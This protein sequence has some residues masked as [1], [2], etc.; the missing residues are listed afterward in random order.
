MKVY[1]TF[2][3]IHTHRCNNVTFDKDCVAVIECSSHKEGREEA[4]RIFN[5]LFHNSYSEKDWNNKWLEFYP[6]GI[7]NI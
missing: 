6:R 2:G 7:I 3:Q 5:K 4:M 1:I